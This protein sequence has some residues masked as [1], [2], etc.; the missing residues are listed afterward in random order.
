VH[1]TERLPTGKHL[2]HAR[3]HFALLIECVSGPAPYIFSYD[4]R[5]RNTPMENN[6]SEAR[7]ALK[8]VISRVG[9]VVPTANLDLPLTLNAVTPF[10]QTFET[11]FGR[12]VRIENGDESP[13][14]PCFPSSSGLQDYMQFIIGPWS[15]YSL[16]Q[17]KRGT[18]MLKFVGPGHSRRVGQCVFICEW[19]FH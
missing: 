12:E 18:Y 10:M 5:I 13:S 11:T 7:E 2:R 16:S 4:T 14:H 9:E 8:Q 3:D 6:L 17:C 15:V 1:V 19:G